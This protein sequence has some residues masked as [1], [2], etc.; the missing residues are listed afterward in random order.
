MCRLFT[1]M[2]RFPFYLLQRF[3]QFIYG[4]QFFFASCILKSYLFDRHFTVK[5]RIN[6]LFGFDVKSCYL[7]SFDSL[8][9]DISFLKL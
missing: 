6:G 4:L 7:Q 8:L 2:N 3:L 5:I 9:A 1:L